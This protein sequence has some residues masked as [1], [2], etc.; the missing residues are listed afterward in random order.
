MV[1]GQLLDVPTKHRKGDN[2][3]DTEKEAASLATTTTKK[4]PSTE[5]QRPNMLATIASTYNFFSFLFN[6]V[7]LET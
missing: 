1:D 3:K 2:P 4:T 5:K 7:L 6:F